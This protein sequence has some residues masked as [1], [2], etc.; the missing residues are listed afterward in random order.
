MDHLDMIIAY[1]NGELSANDTL[2]LFAYL[3]KTGL[4]WSLQG[5]YG[6]TAST[7][8]ELGYITPDGLVTPS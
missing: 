2:A 5:H 7:F 1:E 4:A 3:I 8:I 6:R